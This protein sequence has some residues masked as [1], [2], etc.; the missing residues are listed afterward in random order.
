M[1]FNPRI[2]A[3]LYKVTNTTSP[4]YKSELHAN[5][6]KKNGYSKVP[7]DDPENP[8]SEKNEEK[9]DIE[10]GKEDN[11]QN[12]KEEEKEHKRGFS[13]KFSIWFSSTGCA[14]VSSSY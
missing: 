6:G 2:E 1:F 9:G 5:N 12:K 8:E 11:E 10:E 4:E 13:G 7:E 3:W 14:D